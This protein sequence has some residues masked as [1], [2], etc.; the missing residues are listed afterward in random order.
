MGEEFFEDAKKLAEFARAWSG[1]EDGHIL[2]ELEAYERTLRVKRKLY[3]HDLHALAKIDLV[4]GSKYVPAMVKA[5]LNAPTADSTGHAV[6]FSSSDVSSLLIGGKSRPY[7]KEANGMMQAATNFLT[8]YSRLTPSFQAKLLSDMEVRCVMHVHQKRCDTR[9]SYKSLQHIAKAMY[10]DAKSVDDKLPKWSKL[11]SI[12]EVEKKATI[13]GSLREIRKDGLVADSE[14]TARGFVVGAMIVKK[15]SDDD[16]TTY[17]IVELGNSAKTITVKPLEQ[18][19]ED[20][21]QDT[22]FALDRHEALSSWTLHVEAATVCFTSGEY[23]GPAMYTDMQIDVWKGHIKAALIEAFKK[24]SESGAKVYKEPSVKVVAVQPF[25]VGALSLVGLTNNVMISKGGK[26]ATGLLSLGGCFNHPTHGAMNAYARSHLQ[27]PAAS[28]VSGF[29]RSVVEPFIVAYWAC[30]ETF[31]TSK[32]NCRVN[33]T[34]VSVKIGGVVHKICIPIITNTEKLEADDEIVVLKS[35]CDRESPQELPDAKRLQ[36]AKPNQGQGKGAQAST[37]A[38][39]NNGKKGKSK[40][41]GK[42]SK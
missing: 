6:L 28:S 16:K 20:E 38:Q 19:G 42:A 23:P 36:T 12:A 32:A 37:G 2:R 41:K 40:G 26:H 7:A 15:D 22:Q 5:M 4:D 13:A 3:P 35:S 30:Q 8:A 34:E 21:A 29:A 14:M 9:A 24:S 27:F 11:D 18:D 25:K 31:D 39:Q 1:G 17:T 10:D 33:M